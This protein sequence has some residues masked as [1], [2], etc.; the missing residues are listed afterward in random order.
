M[1]QEPNDMMLTNRF[2]FVVPPLTGHV[3]PTAGLGLAL[4]ARGH[5]VAWCGSEMVLRPLLGDA[6]EVYPTGSKALREQEGQGLP[7]VRSLWQGFVM[8]YARFTAKVVD[9]AMRDFQPD[10]VIVDQ[11][12]PA[13]V[14]AA[15]RHGV[16]WASLASSS[17]ESGR[18]F[19]A[20][21]E[22]ES[23]IAS[24][25]RALWQ[26]GGLPAEDYV[27][28]RFSPDLVLALTSPLLVN[29]VVPASGSAPP[30]PTGAEFA[31]DQYA[32]IGPVLGGRPAGPAFPWERLDPARR[33]VMV[34]M[35]TLSADVS[36]GFHD[37]AAHALRLLGD[38]VQGIVA[39]PPELMD[40]YP[41][42]AVVLP[43]LP[44]LELMS[45]GAL[46]A[47]VCHSGQNTVCEALAHGLPL[48]VAPI[49]HDQPVLAA[50]VAAIGAGTR[51]SFRRASAETLA[52]AIETVLDD[53]AYRAAAEA[54]AKQF[55]ADGGADVAV[56]RLEELARPT[57]QLT[58]RR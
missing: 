50:Q 49:R 9:Q 30:G 38:R 19:R 45:R 46:D 25:L 54:A 8:P 43:R 56:A 16:R 35:G 33:H 3:N 10:V 11:H 14:I 6:A 15:H 34:S 48:V 24:Q 27:D 42:D 18:P 28:P 53:P 36:E 29:S 21:P 32:L 57:P 41:E 5:R 12:T 40:R 17:M 22:V 23:W 2:L 52:Q 58:P 4:A 13:G 55:T 51:I 39:A 31:D 44:V 37:R 47:V 20:L 7:A 1:R 26:R